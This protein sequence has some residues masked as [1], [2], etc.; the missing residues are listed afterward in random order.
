V[1]PC[2]DVPLFQSNPMRLPILLCVMAALNQSHLTSHLRAILRGALSPSTEI[3]TE[4]FS[5][6]RHLIAT[7]PCPF[8]VTFTDSPSANVL[9]LIIARGVFP[10]IMPFNLRLSSFETT[11]TAGGDQCPCLNSAANCY[12]CSITAVS[13]FRASWFNSTFPTMEPGW[14]SAKSCCQA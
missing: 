7:L 2:A 11:R 10:I 14:V 13:N 5:I 6:L 9:P 8:I 1:I 4:S 3:V 12:A